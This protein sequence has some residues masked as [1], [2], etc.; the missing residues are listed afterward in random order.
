[1][2]RGVNM[3]DLMLCGYN[4]SMWKETSTVVA[5][6]KNIIRGLMKDWKPNFVRI[7]LSMYSYPQKMSWLENPEEYKNPMT[8]VIEFLGTYEG[9]Y[10]LVTLRS[11]KTMEQTNPGNEA[12]YI[13]TTATDDTYRALVNSFKNS[14]FVMFGICNE[15]GSPWNWDKLTNVMSHAAKVIRDEEDRLNVSHHIIAVQ[16]WGWSSQ[17][18]HYNDHPLPY[19]N[20]VYEVH[21]YAPKKEWYTLD[22]IPVIIGEYGNGPYGTINDAFFDDLESK[23]IPN[24]AWDFEPYSNCSPDLLQVNHSDTNLVP[25]T[26]G[27]TVKT[28]LLAHS[29]P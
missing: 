14:K 6:L 7:S 23:Q 4:G 12:T 18:G 16:G 25:S 26:W 21:G 1:M 29:P 5:N 11:D 9:V 20:I 13:P 2:G 24:L 3:D 10:V 27:E 8:E 15:P 22:K 28:Y 17:I 19:D